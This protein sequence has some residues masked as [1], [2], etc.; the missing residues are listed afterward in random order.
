MVPNELACFNWF[1]LKF[2]ILTSQ[3]GG[4]CR[5][6]FSWFYHPASVLIALK[7]VTDKDCALVAFDHLLPISSDPK[8]FVAKQSPL[9]I[10]N[11][12]IRTESIWWWAGLMGAIV[13]LIRSEI[14]E[15]SE[16]VLRSSLLIST[17]V[18]HRSSVKLNN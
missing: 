1:E 13:N 15:G 5:T 3:R 11:W 18:F 2:K 7:E 17:S 8:R 9:R 14:F 10:A 4:E 6:R 16:W 12:I